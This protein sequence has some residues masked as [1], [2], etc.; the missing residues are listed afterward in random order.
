MDKE[1]F[2][3]Q[4]RLKQIKTSF[5]E[6]GWITIYESTEDDDV[7]CYLVD[8]SKIDACKSKT[9][10]DIMPSNEGKPSIITTFKEGKSKTTYQTYADNGFEPFIFIKHFNFNDGYEQY[11]DISEEF[12]LYF[13]LY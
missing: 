2:L 13:N 8:N 12:V 1:Y 9:S 11:V 5:I 7:Y 3:M 6:A 10:W 4:D